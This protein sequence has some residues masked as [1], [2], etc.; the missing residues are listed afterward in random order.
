MVVPKILFLCSFICCLFSLEKTNCVCWQSM[1]TL[2]I[3]YPRNEELGGWTS[4]SSLLRA[5]SSTLEYFSIWLCN[6]L[7]SNVYWKLQSYRKPSRLTVLWTYSPEQSLFMSSQFSQGIHT[8]FGTNY[9]GG[10]SHIKNTYGPLLPFYFQKV[11]D[12]Y[13]P[14][15]SECS[16]KRLI[17]IQ[18]NPLTQ[19]VNPLPCKLIFLPFRTYYQGQMFGVLYTQKSQVH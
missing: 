2:M 15:K 17:P 14:L 16:G 11:E 10:F 18:A 3:S 6:W 7:C 5:R 13:V 4:H 19:E 1:C 9:R 8:P 12:Q